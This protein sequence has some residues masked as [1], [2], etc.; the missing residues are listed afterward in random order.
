MYKH[1]AEDDVSSVTTSIVQGPRP[2]FGRQLES[3]S[4]DRSEGRTNAFPLGSDVDAP[5]GLSYSVG[6]D[7]LRKGGGGVIGNWGVTWFT[8]DISGWLVAWE[9]VCY[10]DYTH[11]YGHEYQCV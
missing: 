4:S 6:V 9:V 3:V 7:V 1:I 5:C 10:I 2:S 11:T 8:M